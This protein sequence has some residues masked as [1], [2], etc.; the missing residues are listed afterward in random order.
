GYNYFFHREHAK[1]HVIKSPIP[2][3]QCEPNTKLPFNAVHVP[4]NVSLGD[5]LKGFGCK[6]DTP[7]KNVV[8][9]VVSG[10]GGRWYKG[11]SFH[12]DMKGMMEKTIKDVGWDETRTGQPGEKPVVCLY[13]TKD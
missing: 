11:M 6:N 1:V 12:G 5:L 10:G 4:C 3:W 8:H 7:K 13:F 2:P 9:E